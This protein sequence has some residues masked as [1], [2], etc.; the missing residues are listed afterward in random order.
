MKNKIFY[1]ICLLAGVLISA[2]SFSAVNVQVNSDGTKFTGV[3]V[4]GST[5]GKYDIVFVGDGFTSSSADQ[6]SFNNAVTT[7]VNALRNKHPYMDNICAFNIWRVN[8]ISAQSGVDHPLS[9]VSKN[10]ELNCTFGDNISVPERVIY[11]TTPA[12]VTE[13]A[14]FAPAYD[15]VYVLVNDPQYGGAAG[16]IVYTSLNSSMSEVIVH[17]LGHFVGH[18]ADEYTCY[19]CDGRSEPAYSGPEP[20]QVNLTKQTNRS[21]IKWNSFINPATPVPTTVDNPVR[22]VGLWA[23]GGYSP[24]GI[25]RPQLNCLMRSLNNELCA[26]CNSSLSGILRPFC[27]V[28]ERNPNSFA[29]FISRFKHRFDISV[30]LIRLKIPDCCF[31][32]LDIDKLRRVE[33]EL[34]INQKEYEIQVTDGS[35]KGVRA[36]ISSGENGMTRISFDEQKNQTYF[37]EITPLAKSNRAVMVDAKLIRDGR[38]AVLF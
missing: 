21:L 2:R 5:S 31:C 6:V 8:V 9:S 36:E 1:S 19:F 34:S 23:G 25:Y 38:Q 35:E 22:V 29:C 13:A 7:A 30:S 11:S 15:A 18:L 3:L 24:T 26:V 20:T 32:P 4:N 17:E 33:I 28:C 14:N 27:T 16:S 12:K 37:L 10:T